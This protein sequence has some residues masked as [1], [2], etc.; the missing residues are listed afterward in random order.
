MGE[1]RPHLQV[2]LSSKHNHLHPSVSGLPGSCM[3]DGP[4]I[5]VVDALSRLRFDE[6]LPAR[7]GSQAGSLRGRRPVATA[8]IL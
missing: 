2:I 1:E 7:V 4:V 8:V 6:G 3:P 5:A